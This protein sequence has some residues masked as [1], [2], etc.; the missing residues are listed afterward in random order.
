MNFS[1]YFIGIFLF[2]Q[3]TFIFGE[4]KNIPVEAQKWRYYMIGLLLG[5]LASLLDTTHMICTK[6]LSNQHVNYLVKL[7]YVSYIGV[8]TS[9]MLVLAVDL[10]EIPGQRPQMDSYEELAIQI[11][12]LILGVTAR[13]YQ[14]FYVSLALKHADLSKINIILATDL[15]F[16]FLLQYLILGIVPNWEAIVGAL[17]ILLGVVMVMVYDLLDHGPRLKSCIGRFVSFKF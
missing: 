13:V 16:G 14:G 10:S 6:E 15:L 11:F 1:F 3:P 8:P 9:A 7:S 2:C 4:R 12:F 5:L 17:L